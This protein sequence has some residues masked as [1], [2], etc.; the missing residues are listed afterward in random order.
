M[1]TFAPGKLSSSMNK[2]LSI[3]LLAAMLVACHESLEEKA[4]REAKEFTRRNCPMP[5]SE[6]IVN[7]SMTY[8]ADT[9]T[10]HYYYTAKGAADTT[11]INNRQTRADLVKGVKDATTI[12]T[13]K[14][15][16]FNFAYT[17]YSTKNKGKILLDVKITPKEYK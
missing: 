1:F 11:A 12:R 9:R 3:I 17:Y 15:N 7:D 6:Y 8:D 2:Y 5:V 4:A 16:E 10:I 13:Y 14:E